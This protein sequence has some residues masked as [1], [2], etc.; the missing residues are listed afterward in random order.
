VLLCCIYA[1]LTLGSDSIL[2]EDVTTPTKQPRGSKRGSQAVTQGKDGVHRS[3][4]PSPRTVSLTEELRE[5]K[6][7][8][9]RTLFSRAPT[10][11]QVANLDKHPDCCLPNCSKTA[12]TKHNRKLLSLDPGLLTIA[13]GFGIKDESQ[14]DLYVC[15]ADLKHL[16]WVRDNMVAGS[17]FSSAAGTHSALTDRRRSTVILHCPRRCVRDVRQFPD[18]R[19]AR[20]CAGW[21]RIDERRDERREEGTSLCIQRRFMNS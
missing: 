17:S 4:N 14:P 9:T 10:T 19:N 16:E 2:M 7:N 18:G 1:L 20:G 11:V 12:L 21:K 13:R 8:T 3:G 5:E 15:K 6:S